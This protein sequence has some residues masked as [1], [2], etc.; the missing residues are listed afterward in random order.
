MKKGTGRAVSIKNDFSRARHVYRSIRFIRDSRILQSWRG[1]AAP[2]GP[3]TNTLA[4]ADIYLH[5]AH[6][7]RFDPKAA[8]P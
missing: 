1:R 4:Q 7:A 8:N 2:H 3:I 5:G 6:V